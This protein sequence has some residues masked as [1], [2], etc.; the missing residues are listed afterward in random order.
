MSWRR[1]SLRLVLDSSGWVS[2]TLTLPVPAAHLTRAIIDRWDLYRPL[3]GGAL[4]VER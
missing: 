1:A 3:A 4:W 2:L